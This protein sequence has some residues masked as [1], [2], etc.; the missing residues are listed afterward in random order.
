[1]CELAKC[2]HAQRWS[3]DRV[4]ARHVMEEGPWLWPQLG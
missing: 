4:G 1:M 2:H 3:G